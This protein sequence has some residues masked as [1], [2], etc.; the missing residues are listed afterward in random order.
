LSRYGDDVA[1][2]AGGRRQA[3]MELARARRNRR[4]YAAAFVGPPERGRRFAGG[5]L[6]PGNSTQDDTNILAQGGEFVVNRLA[7]NAVGVQALN[8][9][10]RFAAGGSVPGGD[11]GGGSRG[12]I[13]SL[14]PS[15]APAV[16]K[17]AEESQSLAKALGGF[18]TPASSLAS[19]LGGFGPAA[20]RLA[21]SLEAFPKDVQH[22]GNFQHAVVIN[23]GEAFRGMSEAFAEMVDKKVKEQ[24]E[25]AFARALPDAPRPT[26]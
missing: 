25:A 21:K 23:G 14:D 19:A 1:R 9:L 24:I 26:A 13:A 6:I 15:F 4:G 16:Q 8:K 18:S 20:D 22:S 10:N 11:S 7:V 17:F 2:R 3:A 12:G 5:G